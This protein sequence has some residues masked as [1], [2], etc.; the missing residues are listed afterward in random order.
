MKITACFIVHYSESQSH[1]V[2]QAERFTV[3]STNFTKQMACQQNHGATGVQ[4]TPNKRRENAAMSGGTT[5][6]HRNPTIGCAPPS[7]ADGVRAQSQVPLPAPNKWTWARRFGSSR[8]LTSFGP[9]HR[10]ALKVPAIKTIDISRYPAC[11][12]TISLVMTSNTDSS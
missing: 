1:N 11:S 3:L 8:E 7:G 10:Y 2:L 12:Q 5:R 6:P 9:S 4:P